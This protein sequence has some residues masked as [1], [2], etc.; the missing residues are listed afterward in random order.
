MSQYVSG[1]GRPADMRREVNVLDA[2]Q[3]LVERVAD[4]AATVVCAGAQR[5]TACPPN[6][7]RAANQARA[8]RPD[9]LGVG[10]RWEAYRERARAA[11]AAAMA[12]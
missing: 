7:S 12:R 3:A 8:L 1:E 6:A 11:Q 5:S 2:D 10:G 4:L 9:H